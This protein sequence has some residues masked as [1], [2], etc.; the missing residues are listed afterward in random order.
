MRQLIL[1]KVGFLLNLFKFLKIQSVKIMVISD[2]DLNG[3]SIVPVGENPFV[4]T[5]W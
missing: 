5:I 4:S 2:H 1:F 3:L